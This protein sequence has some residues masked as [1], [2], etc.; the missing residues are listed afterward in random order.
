MLKRLFK[1]RD[2]APA[3]PRTNTLPAAALG[4]D[5]IAQQP[6]PPPQSLDDL[7]ASASAN[8]IQ[9]YGGL[10]INQMIE[11]WQEVELSPER[12]PWAGFPPNE[13]LE[14][15]RAYPRTPFDSI[16]SSPNYLKEPSFLLTQAHR[17]WLT[18]SLVHA[19]CLKTGARRFLDVGSFPFFVSLV[20]RDYFR[21]A[22]DVTVTT[23]IDLSPDGLAF[24]KGKGVRVAK[25]DLDPYVSAPDSTAERLPTRLAEPDGSYDVILSSHVI[26]HLYHPMSLLRE[27]SRLL[28]S[29]GELVI[30]TDNA[31]MIDVFANYIG[32]YG[33]IFEPVEHT[34]A[35]HFDFWRGHV[36]FFTSTDLQRMMH[37]AGLEP[38]DPQYFHCFYEILFPEYF[39]RPAPFT[40]K[41]KLKML[42][43]TPWLR[44]DVA[45]VARKPKLPDADA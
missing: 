37:G 35:M 27:C 26:E 25:L 3:D 36:R 32:G 16:P 14:F 19:N 9:L 24:L 43:Q 7:S 40:S 28:R 1:R 44:N 42:A 10:S 39:K 2:N 23:N 17:I 31:M 6:G 20:L 5:A 29:G 12:E 11:E 4:T 21:F 30:T 22:G 15:V 33:Y 13:F 8:F 45:I 38:S 34:A 41:W 18:A